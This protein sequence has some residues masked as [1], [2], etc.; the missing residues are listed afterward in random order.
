[1]IRDIKL[2]IL[3]AGEIEFPFFRLYFF[4]SVDEGVNKY[5]QLFF[6]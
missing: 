1:M 5:P 3:T 6:N 4:F 2:M